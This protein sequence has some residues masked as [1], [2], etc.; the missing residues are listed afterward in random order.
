MRARVIFQGLTLFISDKSTRG[1]KAGDNVGTLTALLVSDPK[2]ASMPLH[3]HTPR[4]GLNG[5]DANNVT[6]VSKNPLKHSPKASTTVQL[7]GHGAPTG[8][9]LAASFLDYVPCLSELHWAQST[10]I[11]EEFVVARIV[12]PSG[13]VRARNFIGWDWH[14]NTAARIG[15]MGTTFQGFGANEVV[16]DMGDDDDFDRNDTK[17]FLSVN[18]PGVNERLWPRVKGP[19]SDEDMDPNT[20]ELLFTNFPARRLRPAPHGLHFET[21]CDAA[22]YP[23]EE[24]RYVKT[25]QY[26]NF[27][28]AMLQ[29]DR[30]AWLSD[31]GMMGTGQPFPYL[32]DPEAD[33]RDPLRPGGTPPRPMVPPPTPG[34]RAGGP[35]GGMAMGHDPDNTQ[36]CPHGRE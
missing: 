16:I 18:G 25:S 36:I 13:T 6:R 21:T 4:I 7:E 11:R 12:I 5:R 15:Y 30:D 24:N 27:E 23:R 32:V 9:T 14:G 35:G 17:R 3:K 26:A 10:G 19:P 29:Y 33:R 20:A 31:V 2:H 8:V 28:A 34:R 22:G 1:A